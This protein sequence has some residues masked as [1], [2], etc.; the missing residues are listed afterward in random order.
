MRELRFRPWLWYH[1]TGNLLLHGRLDALR[2]LREDGENICIT[3]G[4]RRRRRRVALSG[5]ILA[6]AADAG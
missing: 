5:D 3:W 6:A 2:S 4:R 1:K